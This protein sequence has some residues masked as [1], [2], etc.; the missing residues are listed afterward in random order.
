M[1]CETVI[2]ELHEDGELEVLVKKPGVLLSALLC[3]RCKPCPH[4]TSSTHLSEQEGAAHSQ[5]ARVKD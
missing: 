1:S 3:L 4:Q 5:Q 2:A